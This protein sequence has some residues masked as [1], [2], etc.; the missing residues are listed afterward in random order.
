MVSLTVSDLAMSF[1]R[2]FIN[3]MSLLETIEAHL[4]TLGHLIALRYKLSFKFITS[5]NGWAWLQRRQAGDFGSLFVGSSPFGCGSPLMC[6]VEEFMGRSCFGGL[7]L[8]GGGHL[9]GS[10]YTRC[11]LAQTGSESHRS[12]SNKLGLP[13][14]SCF[15]TSIAHLDCKGPGSFWTAMFR[16]VSLKRSAMNLCLWR[17]TTVD[18][19]A[20]Y[21]FIRPVWSWGRGDDVS[22]R[23]VDR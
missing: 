23:A 2:A 6:S 7:P 17:V 8:L 18:L 19:S 4:E 13:W 1:V 11:C 20:W 5:V 10:S 9:T 21:S 3:L 15:W 22:L 12:R 16:F 14:L